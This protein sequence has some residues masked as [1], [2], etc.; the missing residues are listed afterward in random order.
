MNTAEVSS[1]GVTEDDDACGTVHYDDVDLVKTAGLP[2]EQESVEPGDTFDYVLTV[3]NNG[4]RPAED[5]RVQD[6]DINDRLEILG[7]TVDIDPSRWGPA[8]GF[9][10]ND[11]DLTIDELAVGES[12]VVTVEVE[13]LPA[14]VT[15]AVDLADLPEPSRE[16]ANTACVETL[17]DPID[18]VNGGNNCDSETVPTRDM[19]AAVYTDLRRVTLRFSASS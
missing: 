1:D 12:A 7:L 4:T 19:T 15:D 11:V 8:P 10:G 5:V 3:T 2:S 17:L 16:L 18:G 14:P 13:F 6:D 9:V